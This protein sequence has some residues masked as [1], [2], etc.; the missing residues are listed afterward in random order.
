MVLIQWLL[1]ALYCCSTCSTS[2]SV[3]SLASSPTADPRR[4]PIDPDGSLLLLLVR[5]VVGAVLG[6]RAK[7][8][9]VSAVTVSDHGNSVS[10]LEFGGAVKGRPSA[11]T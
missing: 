9:G 8:A 4:R 6:R 5:S 10:M 2:L 7:K 1:S 11:E 3:P